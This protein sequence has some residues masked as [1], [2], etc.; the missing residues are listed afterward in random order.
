M[1]TKM[2][3]VIRP[4]ATLAIRVMSVMCF[5]F[6]GR[7]TVCMRTICALQQKNS[8]AST[9]I[10]IAVY[11]IEK[12]NL[13]NLAL[14]EHPIKNRVD[15]FQMIAEIEFLFDFAWAEGRRHFCVR[16]EQLEQRQLP[17]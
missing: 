8:N 3:W 14:P 12:C 4:I 16:L 13:I 15:M 6:F 10:T 11:A 17:V 7:R 5:S 1:P 9:A 2:V